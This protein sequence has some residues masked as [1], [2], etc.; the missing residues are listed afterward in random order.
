MEAISEVVQMAMQSTH[1]Y[2]MPP[3]E[4]PLARI[5]SPNSAG[6]RHLQSLSAPSPPSACS[7]TSAY[8][9]SACSPAGGSVSLNARGASLPMDR[10]HASS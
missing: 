6:A 4:V 2:E 10:P 1:R 7:T 9:A 3:S 5:K 8:V